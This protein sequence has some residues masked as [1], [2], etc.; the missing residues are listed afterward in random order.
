MFSRMRSQGSRVTLGVCGVEGV[1]ARRC[2][3][4]R[5]R[6]QP[7]ENVRNRS[8]PFAT[9]RGRACEGRMAIPMV[10]SAK[11]VLLPSPCLWGKLPNLSFSKVSTQIVMSYCVAS[12]ALGD[13]LT[14]LQRGRKSFCGFVWQAQYFCVLFRRWVALFVAGAALWRH[15]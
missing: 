7:F 13:I 15:T 10:S 2:V 3:Y 4:V 1:F 14:C 11:G 5:N 8:Q 9:V 12:V 6:L